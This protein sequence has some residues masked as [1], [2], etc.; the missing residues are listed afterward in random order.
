MDVEV[1]SG[2]VSRAA[3]I[4]TSGRGSLRRTGR[5][6]VFALRRPTRPA[7]AETGIIHQTMRYCR[8]RQIEEVSRGP[9]RAAARARKIVAQAEAERIGSFG[10][11]PQGGG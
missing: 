3:W 4:P 6:R 2:L 8:E 11:V 1:G 10:R 9:Q 7:T 5:R